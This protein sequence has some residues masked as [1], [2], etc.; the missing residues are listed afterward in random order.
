[1]NPGL[2]KLSKFMSLVLRHNPGEIGLEL[3]ENGWADVAEL[4]ARANLKGVRLTHSDLVTIVETN[5]KKRFA[6]NEDGTRIRASQGH[7]IEVD[8]A[9]SAVAPPVRLFHGTASRFVE[10]IRAQGLLRGRRQ[11]VH[12]SVDAATATKV[13]QRHGKPVVVHVL[14]GEMHQA[15]RLFYLSAN[16]VW[17]TEHVPAEYLVFPPAA[18]PAR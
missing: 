8:L 12:L 9:L 3:D 18:Q 6:L 15:G 11:H 2:V 13:G 17:L 14:A 5:D 10:S 16:G 1:V 4:I 7:S